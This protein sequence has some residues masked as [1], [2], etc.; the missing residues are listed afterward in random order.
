MVN[1]ILLLLVAIGIIHGQHD[2]MDDIIK[3]GGNVVNESTRSNDLVRASDD[4]YEY[5]YVDEYDYNLTGGIKCKCGQETDKSLGEDYISGGTKAE[6]NQYPWMVQ[7]ITRYE[8][9]HWAFMKAQSECGG[10]LISD[11]HILTA[12]HC[13]DEDNVDIHGVPYRKT[14]IDAYLGISK[15]EDIGETG[16]KIMVADVLYPVNVS[17]EDHDMAMVVLEKPVK[18]R[19]AIQ[20]VCLPGKHYK[21]NGMNGTAMGWGNVNQ[22]ETYDGNLKHVVVPIKEHFEYFITTGVREINGV[23][24]DPCNGDSGGPLVVKDKDTRKWVLVGTVF[25]NGYNC[26]HNEYYDDQLWN[27][28]TAHLDW[29]YKVLIED[30]GNYCPN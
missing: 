2:T 10:A 8:G 16:E 1:S 18:F 6:I 23:A 24:Q 14:H 7:L 30:N 12:K 25:A 27:R 29:I 22:K 17:K 5:G 15:S 3:E 9:T 28:V 13:V 21:P 4:V 19:Q 20:T 26:K 11:R